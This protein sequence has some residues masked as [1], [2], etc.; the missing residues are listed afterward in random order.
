MYYT[1]PKS[2]QTY[3]RKKS[4]TKLLQKIFEK[5]KCH[6][7]YEEKNFLQE[8]NKNNLYELILEEPKPTSFQTFHTIVNCNEVL[9]KKIRVHEL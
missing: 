9:Y 4:Y 1:Y 2:Y 5:E 7:M 3:Y 6:L 8:K